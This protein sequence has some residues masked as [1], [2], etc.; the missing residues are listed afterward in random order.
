LT[1]EEKEI[2]GQDEVREREA[3]FL[4]ELPVQTVLIDPIIQRRLDQTR[5]HKIASNF[6]RDAIGV[7]TASRRTDGRYYALDG[8]HRKAAMELLGL[9]DELVQV[10]AF[11]GLSTRDE[12]VL[13]RLLNNTKHPQPLDIFRVQILEK[14]PVALRMFELLTNHGWKFRIGIK[15]GNFM[16]VSTLRR[17]FDSDPVMAETAVNVLCLAWGNRYGT[18]NDKLLAGLGRLLI[19]RGDQMDVNHLITRLQGVP[20][21]PREVLNRAT[22]ISEAMKMTHANAVALILVEIYNEALRSR[23]LNPWT[24]K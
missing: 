8:Q 14:D 1:T 5:V 13:F 9:G 3:P 4:I 24:E 23:K 21:G 18:L 7:L 22:T 16:A 15:D 10:K 2:D 20:G 19:R 17:L 6:N 12:A 11:N